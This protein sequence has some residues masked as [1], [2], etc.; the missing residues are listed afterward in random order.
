MSVTYTTAHGNAGSLTHWARPGIAPTTSWLLVRFISTE[1]LPPPPAARFWPRMW[2]FL[3]QGSDPSHCSARSLTCCTTRKLLLLHFRLKKK[4]NL[5][6]KKNLDWEGNS[7]ISINSISRF[8]PQKLS[9]FELR[10]W[11]SKPFYSTIKMAAQSPF[12]A[13]VADSD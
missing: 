10:T 9:Y 2:K 13:A 12:S 11:L 1:P 3:G 6:L 8:P 5:F 7:L 4:K